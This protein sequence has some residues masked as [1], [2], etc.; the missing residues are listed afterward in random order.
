[1]S[2]HIF[3]A[4][5]LSLLV[6]CT[7]GD[8]AGEA[9]PGVGPWF[10]ENCVPVECLFQCCQGWAWRAKPSLR[11]GNLPGSACEEVRKTHPSYSEYVYLMQ[12][13]Q[14]YCSDEFNYFE[15]GY[16]YVIEPSDAIKAFGAGGEPEYS[17]LG[18]LVCPPRGQ[19]A[20]H[21]LEDVEFAPRE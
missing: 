3:G 15:S 2:R 12:Q 9:Q 6:G 17:G 5:T 4:A 20:A 21:P 14:N 18:F 11:G 16:C 10:D 1:M 8:E 13:P 7:F 19:E